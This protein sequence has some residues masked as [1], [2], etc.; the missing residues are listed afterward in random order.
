MLTSAGIT[1]LLG[2]SEVYYVNLA[3]L[4]AQVPYGEVLGLHVP[5]NVAVRMHELNAPDLLWSRKI[6]HYHLLGDIAQSEHGQLAAA[7]L[8]EVFQV[9]PQ[10]VHD[11]DVVLPFATVPIQLRDASW[12]VDE[13]CFL[14]S[15]LQGFEDLGL[16]DDLWGPSRLHLLW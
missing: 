15:A 7:L 9:R 2:E 8:L 12:Q 14:T 6:S 1:I 11:H 5:V 16:E 13:A 4:G 3:P 10:E